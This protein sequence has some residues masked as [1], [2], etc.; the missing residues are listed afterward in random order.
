MVILRMPLYLNQGFLLT[1]E[2]PTHSYY[3]N[4]INVDILNNFVSTL[5]IQ[6]ESE[7]ILIMDACHSGNVNSQVNNGVMTTARSLSK[8]IADEVRLLSCQPNEISLEG[9]EWGE[10]RGL[11]SYHLING[12]MG[13]ADVQAQHDGY[14]TLNELNIYLSTNVP[15]DAAPVS[16]YP[17]VY[18]PMNKRIARTNMEFVEQFNRNQ[19]N[20]SKHNT[21][22]SGKSYEGNFTADLSE[23]QKSIYNAFKAAIESERLQQPENNSAYHHWKTLSEM[24][25]T[26]S[27]KALLKRE[28]I[29]ALQEEPQ[30][31]INDLLEITSK[32]KQ[33]LKFDKWANKLKTFCRVIR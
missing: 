8:N 29:A 21:A 28:L 18:G 5:S 26:A 19:S 9:K 7:V 15:K 27:F 16:Q 12:M 1:H 6:N 33:Q 31:Y 32:Q 25:V 11:F 14:V 23:E 13:L 24:D 2:T 17:G 10:G 4:S 20:I 30:L 22:V 3:T